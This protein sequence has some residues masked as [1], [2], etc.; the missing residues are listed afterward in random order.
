MGRYHQTTGISGKSRRAQQ[1]FTRV[2]RLSTMRSRKLCEIFPRWSPDRI[3]SVHSVCEIFPSFMDTTRII[4]REQVDTERY[5][6]AIAFYPKQYRGYVKKLLNGY[7]G[8]KT[9]E[10]VASY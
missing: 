3:A 2:L 1:I 9:Y 4:C 7:S 10:K 8:K 5:L 6:S